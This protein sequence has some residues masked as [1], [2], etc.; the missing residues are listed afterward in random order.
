MIEDRIK[1]K[2]QTMQTTTQAFPNCKDILCYENLIK[3]KIAYQT[4]D[5]ESGNM[6]LKD[7]SSLRCSDEFPEEKKEANE[8]IN[9]KTQEPKENKSN[10]EAESPDG[11]GEN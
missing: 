8:I 4:G 6:H 2:P 7:F 1:D 3:S 5:S 11:G 9:I 10:E